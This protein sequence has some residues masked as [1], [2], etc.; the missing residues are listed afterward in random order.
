MNFELYEN[1]KFEN[2]EKL[3]SISKKS[4]DKL[5]LIKTNYLRNNQYFQESINFLINIKFFTINENSTII[6]HDSDKNLKETILKLLC[7]NPDYF[8]CIKNYL[9]NF[10]KNEE[11]NLIFEPDRLYNNITSNLRNFLITLDCVKFIT[12][13]QYILLDTNLLL[14]FVKKEFSPKQLEKILENQKFLGLAAEKVI[15]NYE[16]IRIK[17]FGNN[18]KLD[19]VSLRDVSAGYDI[20][21]YEGNDKIFI[22]V[23]AVSLS[24]YKFHLSILEY[25]TAINL[26]EKY[27]IYLLPVD[28]SK[29]DNFDIDNLIRINNLYENIFNNKTLW[30]MENDGYIFYKN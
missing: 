28:H 18:L 30:K 25:Q 26:K 16:E 20:Q 2:L 3:I 5:S 19:H 6:I 1:I 13:N 24:N 8:V 29:P 11:G 7:E 21:S 15:I 12:D 14:Q 17:K 27:Y 23:K 22:E 9:M 10:Q 4:P